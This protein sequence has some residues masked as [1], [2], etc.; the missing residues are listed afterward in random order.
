MGAS[1][2]PSPAPVAGPDPAE[3]RGSD[4]AQVA[5]PLPLPTVLAAP[6]LPFGREWANAA[7]W[8]ASLALARDA[9]SGENWVPLG[10]AKPE[11]EGKPPNMGLAGGLAGVDAVIV[12]S[13]SDCVA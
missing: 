4:G 6:L 5:N 7:R 11:L 2:D 13:S 8:A 3:G 12:K 10:P 1:D 9:P